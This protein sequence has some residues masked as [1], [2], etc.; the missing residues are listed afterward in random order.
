MV[1]SDLKRN[2]AQVSKNA[3]T[4]GKTTLRRAGMQCNTQFAAKSFICNT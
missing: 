2:L 3:S 1:P 4:G